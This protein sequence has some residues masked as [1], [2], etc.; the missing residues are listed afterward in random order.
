MKG[1]R[2]KKPE[3]RRVSQ[4][5]REI[6][7][8]EGTGVEELEIDQRRLRALL[9]ANEGREQDHRQS[10]E[11]KKERR[12]RPPGTATAAVS[13][14]AIRTAPFQSK[15]PSAGRSLVGAST[16]QP[17]TVPA[18]PTGKLIQNTQRQSS[19]SSTRPPIAGPA[20]E[21]HRLRR[22]LDAQRPPA[23]FVSSRRHNDGDA[24]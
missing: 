3:Q 17:R 11:A 15:L 6:A 12:C 9:G 16:N 5:A 10:R 13:A 14:G 18:R 19:M 1:I 20:L 23:Q 22:S 21:S 7:G 4:Q 2:K 8:R 24:I